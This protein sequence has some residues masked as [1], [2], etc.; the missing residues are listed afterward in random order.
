MRELAEKMFKKSAQLSTV[1]LSSTSPK[2][3]VVNTTE[4]S[5]NE[6][7]IHFVETRIKEIESEEKNEYNNKLLLKFKNELIELKKK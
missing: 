5:Q 3:P 4:M 6:R 7:R 2:I 1:Q